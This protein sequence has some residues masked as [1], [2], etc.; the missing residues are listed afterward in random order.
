MTAVCAACGGC[1]WV[2]RDLPAWDEEFA[3]AV[4]CPV[5]N[6]APSPVT[7][8]PLVDRTERPRLRIV[9]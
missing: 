5:C 7:R 2:R 9:S 6:P 8:P 1:G 4:R 3:L